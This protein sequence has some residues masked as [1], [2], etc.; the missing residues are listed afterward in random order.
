MT[1]PREFLTYG[2][3]WHLCPDCRRPENLKVTCRHCGSEYPRS[4]TRA[5][6][7]RL[8]VGIPVAILVVLGAMLMASLMLKYVMFPVLDLIF[9][10]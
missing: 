6:A 8:A 1:K 7:L 9:R 10:V 2:R 3:L 4:T 5:Q